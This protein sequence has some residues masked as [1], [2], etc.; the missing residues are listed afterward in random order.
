MASFRLKS[1]GGIVVPPSTGLAPNVSWT[2]TAGSGYSTGGGSGVAV[3]TDPTRKTAK[4]WCRPLFVNYDT[5]AESMTIGVDAGVLSG[6][7]TVESVEFYMEGNTYLVAAE[8]YYNYTDVNGASRWT[9]G[10][11]C[12]IDYA[13][14]MFL[15]ATGAVEIYIK[16]TPSNAGLQAQVI[17]PFVLYARAPGTGVGLQYD[18]ALE[19]APSQG[20][21]AGVRYSSIKKCLNYLGANSKVRGLITITENATLKAEACT[22]GIAT[23]TS[24]TTITTAPGVSATFGD[25][26]REDT[27]GWYIKSDGVRFMGSGVVIDTAGLNY[28]LN[29]AIRCQTVSNK[30]LWFDGCEILTG[31]PNPAQG[32]SGSGPSALWKGITSKSFWISVQDDSAGAWYFTEVNAHDLCG[33]GLTGATLVRC[34][35]TDG[36]SGSGCEVLRGTMHNCTM[37][38]IGG[39]QWGLRT[40][41]DGFTLTYTGAKTVTYACSGSPDAT[42][43]R[44]FTITID[45]APTTLAVTAGSTNPPQISDLVTWINST[46]A[47]SGLVAAIPGTPTRAACYVHKPGDVQSAAIATT[48][49]VSGVTNTIETIMD[50]HGDCVQ[51]GGGTY[52]NV[53]IRFLQVTEAIGVASVS[54]D[55]S[56]TMRDAGVRNVSIQDTSAAAGWAQE[57][58]YW[59]S[60]NEHLAL[61]YLS[62]M[63]TGAFFGTSFTADAYCGVN[64]C[65]LD[66]LFWAI[67]ADPDIAITSLV[68]RTGTLPSGYDANSKT[69]GGVASSTLYTSTTIPDFTPLTPLQLTDLAWAGRLLPT[70]V[71][72]GL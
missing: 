5:F 69:L 14:T 3:P 28:N 43:S 63:D 52:E 55:T 12:P 11:Q 36:V 47:E 53:S 2:G 30:L 17:G 59:K 49:L 60:D 57:N 66:E 45:G 35:N 21:V 15:N 50:A 67:A 23:A 4:P 61:E 25:G 1:R 34:C 44:T 42:A 22:T 24:W 27:T 6:L 10:F 20:D 41:G 62:F 65:S 72:Q 18:Y 9:Y 7:G 70:G 32:G 48:T 71:E 51:F 54:F 26:T 31:T 33:Y 13:T 68:V 38:Q 64:Q 39:A 56:A 8:S 58:G 40:A 37:S 19:L 46:V 29:S 16:A